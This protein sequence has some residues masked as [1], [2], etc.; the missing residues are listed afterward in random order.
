MIRQVKNNIEPL[1]WIAGLIFLA[2]QNPNSIYA[3]M[4][5]SDII[6]I[7]NCPGCGL[8]TSISYLFDG[9]IIQSIQTHFLGIP[10]VIAIIFRI[11]KIIKF[12][13]DKHIQK[14][15]SIGL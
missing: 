6:G 10:V 14:S 8:G 2:L 11:T 1:F 4:C 7:T 3:S 9:Q 5:L 15:L 13:I 12:K